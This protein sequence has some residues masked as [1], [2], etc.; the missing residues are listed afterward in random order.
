[1]IKFTGIAHNT[2]MFLQKEQLSD[3]SLWAK[4]VDVYRSQPDGN[5]NGWR[6]EYWG[7]MMRG[8]C[9]V[10]EYTQ[11]EKLYSTLTD[12]VKDM[13]TVADTD[14]RVS[15]FPRDNEFI[16][17]DMWCRKYVILACEYYIDICR[18]GA[19]KS[20]IIQFI[21]RATDYIIFRIGNGDGQKNINKASNFWLGLNSS[22][23]LE[24]IEIGRAHV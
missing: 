20:E 18:D 4:F 8:A 7:K 9:L 1:M 6:G 13:M 14:G 11:D 15:S 2:A 3:P 5:N 23:I 21:S 19:L 10:Y 22:S 16:A 12:S 17:W 24:P